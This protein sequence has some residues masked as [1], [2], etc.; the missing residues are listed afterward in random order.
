MSALQIFGGLLAGI[1]MLFLL[2]LLIS[3]CW[4]GFAFAVV[5]TTCVVGGTLLAAGVV[6]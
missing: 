1:P 5:L 2:I 6:P 3:E 4:Q